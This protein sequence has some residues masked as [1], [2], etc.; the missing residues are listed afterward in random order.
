MALAAHP[1]AL[2]ILFIVSFAESSVFPIPPDVLLIPMVLAARGKW[3]I[4]AAV[5]TV[6]S[7]AG[8]WLGYALGAVFHQQIGAPVLEMYGAAGEFEEL[9]RRFAEAGAG[10]VFF[11]ALTPF[12]YKVVTIFSGFMSLDLTLFTVISVIGRGIRYFL[13]AWLL[14]RFGEPVRRFIEE[15]LGLVFT[16]FCAA[17]IGGFLFIRVL[18]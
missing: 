2:L 14:Y 15:R 5:C 12:P 18:K 8:G 4:I 16:L 11:A 10:A 1:R 9:R 6:S 17:L 7:V 3:L 13:A